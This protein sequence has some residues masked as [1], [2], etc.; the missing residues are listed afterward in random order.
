MVSGC[1]QMR[2]TKEGSNA[3]RLVFFQ[4]GMIEKKPPPL[5]FCKPEKSA[6]IE[7]GVIL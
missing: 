4:E 2:P 7:A 1:L 5:G 6:E 3:N